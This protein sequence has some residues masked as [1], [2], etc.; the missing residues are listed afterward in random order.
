MKFIA[1]L[2]K[3]D[4]TLQEV[5]FEIQPCMLSYWTKAFGKYEKDNDIMEFAR[6]MLP[7]T[8]VSPKE[9]RAV[10]AFGEDFIGLSTV[11][12]QIMSM[13][14]EKYTKKPRKPLL[15]VNSEK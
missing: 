15:I 12:A 1:E 14:A 5:T 3:L 8:V 11:S 9:Y 2:E 13:M 10:E 6:I 4:G 7:V